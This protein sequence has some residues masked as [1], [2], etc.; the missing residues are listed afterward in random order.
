V[1]VGH[2]VR[3]AQVHVARVAAQP[4]DGVVQHGSLPGGWGVWRVLKIRREGGAQLAV[5]GA[6]GSEG[7]QGKGAGFGG[8]HRRYQQPQQQP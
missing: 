3:A 2:A 5:Q 7:R 8:R 4:A 6:E 1:A